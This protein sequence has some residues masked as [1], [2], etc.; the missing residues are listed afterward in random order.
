MDM[1]CVVAGGGNKNL[2]NG[3]EAAPRAE[4]VTDVPMVVLPAGATIFPTSTRCSGNRSDLP[5]RL[6]HQGPCELSRVPA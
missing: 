3:D 4:C 1:D 2:I 6:P 5:Q